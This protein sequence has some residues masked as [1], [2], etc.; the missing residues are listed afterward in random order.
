MY[1]RLQGFGCRVGDVGRQMG[2][3]ALPGG[4]LELQADRLHKPAVVIRD[5]Y[6]DA[7][8]PAALEPGEEAYPAAFRLAVAQLQP[9]DLAVAGR[10]HTDGEERTDRT[11]ASALTHL[12]DQGIHQHER[13]ALPTQI[14][15]VPRLYQWIEPLAQVGHGRFGKARPAQLLRDAC[16]FARRD[17]IDH[18]LHQRQ[19]ERLLTPLVPREQ[20]GREGPLAH[21][22][23]TEHEPANPCRQPAR[24]IAVAVALP[25]LGPFV[26]HGLQLL[27]DLCLEHL[28][29]DRLQE[30][31]ELAVTTEELLQGLRIK[32]NLVAGH[33]TSSLIL[34]A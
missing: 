18:H 16:D 20:L 34:D 14:P 31:A 23:H 24:L 28:I 15:L 17:T 25:L 26:G 29:Q 22:G 4:A 30:L 3:A 9:K 27:S 5:H 7:G 12:E 10:V 8:Q 33:G 11:Y 13:I 21:L 19:N 32:G 1:L 2:L 6:V